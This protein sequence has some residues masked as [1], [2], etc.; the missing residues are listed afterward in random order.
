MSDA[1]DRAPD[2]FETL[3][4]QQFDPFTARSGTQLVGRLLQDLVG[5]QRPEMVVEIGA[6]YTTL[7][8]ARAL[9]HAAIRRDLEKDKLLAKSQ[10]LIESICRR[11]EQIDPDGPLPAWL[12]LSVYDFLGQGEEASC[13]DP[14]YYLGDYR[15]VLLSFDEAPPESAYALRLRDALAGYDL[16]PFVELRFEA[17]VDMFAAR[18]SHIARPI[19]LFWCDGG[20]YRAWF[21]AGWEWLRPG[22]TMVFH[23][24]LASHKA[25][26]DWIRNSRR[27]DNDIDFYEVIEPNKLVQNGAYVVQK[28]RP[29]S[30]SAAVDTQS[31]A[32][33]ILKSVDALLLREGIRTVSVFEQIYSPEPMQPAAR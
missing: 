18:L 20:P 4:A 22:G 21:S 27:R 15:P 13:A 7:L 1:P 17:G 32:G 25:D 30:L 24:G 23:R 3:A 11:G 14:A 5:T 9:K 29:S 2:C 10:E 12:T 6:G 28:R 19:D 8:I 26:I 16:Q 33:S 31:S